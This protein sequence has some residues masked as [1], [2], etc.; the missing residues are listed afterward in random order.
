MDIKLNRTDFFTHLK[1][2]SI[3]IL[4]GYQTMAYYSKRSVEFESIVILNGYQTRR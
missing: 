4:N 3:V 2:E 1:F